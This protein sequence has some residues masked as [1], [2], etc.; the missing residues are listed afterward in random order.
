M[1]QITWINGKKAQFVQIQGEN[2]SL[3][4]EASFAPGTPAQ[5]NL[6]PPL[7]QPITVK[8]HSCR[9]EEDHFLITGRLVN[10]TR[11]LRTLLE[12]AH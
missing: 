4:S 10:L 6:P 7:V 9:R 8:V 1:L 5:G 12:A 3:R 11:E 2:I